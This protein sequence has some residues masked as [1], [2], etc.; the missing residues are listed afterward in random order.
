M[1]SKNVKVI[2]VSQVDG[3]L[4]V[5]GT[6]GETP[7]TASPFQWGSKMLMKVEAEGLDR[8]SRIAIGHAA[9][10]AL[11]VAELALPEAVLKRPRKP[12]A[13]PVQEVAQVEELPVGF[14]TLD[15]ALAS[16]E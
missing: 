9:K 14:A 3:K 15:E 6:V 10:R 11:K 2:E 13:E 12:K 16:L 1:A 5:F 4:T 8:G 7:F